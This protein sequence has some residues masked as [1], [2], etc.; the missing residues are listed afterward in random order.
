MPFITPTSRIVF[1]QEGVERSCELSVGRLF[2]ELPY[3]ESLGL[4]PAGFEVFSVD[5]VVADEGVGHHQDLGFI[6]WVGQ[7]LLVAGHGGV[8]DD[9]AIRLSCG[10]ESDAFHYRPVLHDKHCVVFVH[11]CSIYL[12]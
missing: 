6:R 7:G 5:S 2:C 12:N 8:E 11:R 10:S 4:Y 1:L 9:F 3:Y